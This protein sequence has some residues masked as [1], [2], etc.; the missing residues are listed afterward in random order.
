LVVT[1][2]LFKKSVTEGVS[3]PLVVNSELVILP[4]LAPDTPFIR[5]ANKSVSGFTGVPGVVPFVLYQLLTLRL[6]LSP[7]IT[8]NTIEG[9]TFWLPV[10]P[11]TLATFALGLV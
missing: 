11:L 4:A 5:I 1:L 2:L 8:F 7:A 9:P 3:T 6:N 10:A